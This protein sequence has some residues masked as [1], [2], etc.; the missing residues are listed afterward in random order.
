MMT[1]TG[2][3]VGLLALLGIGGCSLGRGAPAPKHFVLGGGVA[4]TTSGPARAG[5]TGVSIG[6]R[7]PQLATYPGSPFIVS[8]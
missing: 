8:S 4:Q 3:V 5:L 7:R 2:A 6:I 1:R